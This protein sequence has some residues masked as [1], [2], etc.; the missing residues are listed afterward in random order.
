MFR[1]GKKNGLIAFIVCALIVVGAGSAALFNTDIQGISIETIY[2][3]DVP[4]SDGLEGFWMPDQ[5]TDQRQDTWNMQ[6]PQ[7]SSAS[8]SIGGQEALTQ[9]A[10]N[11]DPASLPSPQ[12]APEPNAEIP[13]VQN[14]DAQPQNA[15]QPM[16]IITSNPDGI[17]NVGQTV[18]LSAHVRGFQ[19]GYQLTWQ[20]LDGSGD[21]WKDIDG[22]HSKSLKVHINDENV[23]YQWR[24]WIESPNIAA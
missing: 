17:V 21:E 15:A 20:V 7:Q 5:P 10:F 8:S 22:A 14:E 11:Q 2:E 1:T 4:L 12:S 9:A 16:V 13:S 18:K 24:V 3:M 6:E 23:N 19:E